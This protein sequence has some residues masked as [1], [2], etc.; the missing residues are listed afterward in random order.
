MVDI[1]MYIYIYTRNT[2]MPHTNT[3][4]YT[5][6]SAFGC[7]LLALVLWEK[8]NNRRAFRHYT[9]DKDRN[10]FFLL[11]L[12]VFYQYTP[13]AS[14]FRRAADVVVPTQFVNGIT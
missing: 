9:R 14:V 8:D 11:T 13:L 5:T 6:P 12:L 7:G 3:R 10:F 2:L 1:Y 4:C